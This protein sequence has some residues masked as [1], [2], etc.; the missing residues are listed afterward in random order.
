MSWNFADAKNLL[1]E[2]IEMIFHPKF[3]RKRISWRYFMALWPP[4]LPSN[5]AAELLFDSIL[6]SV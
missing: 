2:H 3:E 6:L 1:M 5:M 4:C